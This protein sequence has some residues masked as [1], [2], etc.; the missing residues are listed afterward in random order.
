MSVILDL[1]KKHSTCK[2]ID[3]LCS[4]ITLH[5]FQGME[6]SVLFWGFYFV[7]IHTHKARFSYIS[8]PET[9]D[10]SAKFG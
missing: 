6:F 8:A 7:N 1:R 2:Y 3:I 4:N 9:V 10:N 5:D